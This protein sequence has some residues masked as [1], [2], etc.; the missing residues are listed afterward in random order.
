LPAS[1]V[2]GERAP[3]VEGIIDLPAPLSTMA[4]PTEI[5]ALSN[6]RTLHRIEAPSGRVRSL[7]LTGLG[8]DASVTVG[9]DAI[10]VASGRDVTLIADDAPVTRTMV[11]DGI[12]SVQP[13]TGSTSFIVTTLG[14]TEQAREQH[15]IVGE[16]GDV[17][18]LDGL[19]GEL[20][21]Q[22]SFLPTG[23]ILVTR[24]G[25]VYAVAVGGAVRRLSPGDLLGSGAGHYAVE[26]CD[27]TLQC[28]QF[29]IDATTGARSPAALEDVVASGAG[30]PSTRIAPDGRHVAFRDYFRGTGVRR[31]VDVTTGAGI[32]IGPVNSFV[33]ADTWTADGSGLFL[34]DD[35]IRFFDVTT[36]ATVDLDEFAGI[37]EVVARP[38]I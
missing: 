20:A 4:V 22:A 15:W 36:G 21:F 26:E 8:L 2:V 11:A 29:V 37:R 32:D 34:A 5:V 25:G 1:V 16:G 12:V 10:V 28:A 7:D 13:W 23:E 9:A 33:D 38:P 3:W 14:V 24:P 17:V 27:E 19:F 18:A 35:T 6:S 30:D 31:V